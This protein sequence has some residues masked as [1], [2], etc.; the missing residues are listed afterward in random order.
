MA[1]VA[2]NIDKDERCARCLIHPYGFSCRKGIQ[3][4]AFV[5]KDD[6]NVSLL[7]MRYATQDFCFSHGVNIGGESFIGLSAK[8]TL[9]ANIIHGARNF[10]I[11]QGLFLNLL[12]YILL[13]MRTMSTGTQP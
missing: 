11:K 1:I 10:P 7:R 9:T 3:P 5:P 8:M 12:S 13:L 6:N 2:K 4:A